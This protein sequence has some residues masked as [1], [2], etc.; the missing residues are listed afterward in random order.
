MDKENFQE[1]KKQLFDSELSFTEKEDMVWMFSDAT[2]EEIQ[3]AIELFSEDRAWIKKI[4]DNY[5]SKKIALL[6]DDAEM[7]KK[8]LEEEVTMVKSA[9]KNPA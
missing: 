8:I 3:A 7:W 4:S 1:L 6:A 9:K 5:H 2:E